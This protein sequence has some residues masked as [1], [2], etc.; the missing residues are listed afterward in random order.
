[1]NIERLLFLFN[2]LPPERQAQVC[3][4]VEFVALRAYPAV[5]RR[6]CPPG[7][8]EPFGGMWAGRPIAVDGTR[9]ARAQRKSES[10]PDATGVAARR[11]PKTVA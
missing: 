1:M 5:A 10:S 8:N 7:R 9:R 6:K 3:D 2:Q 11:H 4:F